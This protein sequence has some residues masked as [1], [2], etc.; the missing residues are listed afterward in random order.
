MH[1]YAEYARMGAS[2][3]AKEKLVSYW[4]Y[5][6][7]FKGKKN[8]FNTNQERLILNAIEYQYL[9]DEPEKKLE[10]IEEEQREETKRTQQK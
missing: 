6:N 8:K 2:D 3:E 9:D 10:Q 5:Y 4:H 1:K 7:T